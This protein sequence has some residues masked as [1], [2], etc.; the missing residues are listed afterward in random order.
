MISSK[1]SSEI[2]IKVDAWQIVRCFWCGTPE[3]PAWT[4]T[5]TGVYCSRE[6]V[7]ASKVDETLGNFL[8][9]VFIFPSFIAGSA[10]IAGIT[11]IVAYLGIFL[12][13]TV[14][15]SPLLIKGL[16]E[17]RHRRAVPRY[18]RDAVVPSNTSLLKVLPPT[19]PC[20]QCDTSIDLKKVGPDMAY[21]CDQCGATG[22]IKILGAD[23]S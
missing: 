10:R 8:L 23:L 16:G 11:S 21:R 2:Y 4:T 15:F 12:V 6:C 20:P 18:S 1:S 14:L 3:S 13:V 19:A 17:Y 9:A 7:Q 22:T 5:H